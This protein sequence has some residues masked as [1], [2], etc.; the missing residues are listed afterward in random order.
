MMKIAFLGSRGIPASYSGFETFYEQLSVRL[1]E[2]GHQVTVYNRVPHVRHPGSH[3]L[4]VRLVKLPTIRTK[5]LDTPVH[6]LLSVLHAIFQRYDI[7]YF[8]GVGNAPMTILPRLFGARTLLNVDGADWTREKWGKGASLYLR[9]CESIACRFPNAVIAD[10]KVIRD[11]YRVE[12]STDTVFIPYGANVVECDREDVL[13]KLSLEAD[14]YLLFVGRLVPENAAHTL[15]QAFMEMQTDLKL[16]IVGDAPYSDAYKRQL[17]QSAGKNVVFTGYLFG[18]DYQALSCKT[19][20]YVLPSRV[21]GTRPV[22]LDQMGFGNCVLVAN[23]RANLEVIGDAGLSFDASQGTSH[24]RQQMQRLVAHP[25]LVQDC[26]SRARKR[27]Q[28]HYSWE[29]VTDQYERLF[30]GMLP[31]ISR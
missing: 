9:L 8:C 16:V 27:V 30:A 26:R 24:L 28:E 12:Y 11:R 14:R 6:T 1:V 18:E 21:E 10:S 23:S 4:G 29:T 15:V 7:V 22:L 2:R 19:L 20:F 13:R 17:K 3:Y 25:E 31:G 5:H